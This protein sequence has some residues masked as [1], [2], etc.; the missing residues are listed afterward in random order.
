M[1]N[2]LGL[3]NVGFRDLVFF[4]YLVSWFQMSFL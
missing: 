3:G 2:N 1:F 4:I